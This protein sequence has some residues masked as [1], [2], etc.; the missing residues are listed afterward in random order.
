MC[1]QNTTQIYHYINQIWGLIDFKSLAVTAKYIHYYIGKEP[2]VLSQNT[3][4]SS[5]KI[6]S[7]YLCVN[8]VVLDLLLCDR[9]VLQNDLQPHRHHAGHPADQAG[10]DVTGHSPLA[11]QVNIALLFGFCTILVLCE[12]KLLI[13]N[14]FFFV[15]QPVS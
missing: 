4:H 13:L 14:L 6:L 3:M 12:F 15:Y 11:Q 1:K 9:D 5:M 7:H 10:A 2:E 8:Y